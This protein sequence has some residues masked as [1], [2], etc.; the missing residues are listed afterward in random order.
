M[1]R[2][3]TPLLAGFAVVA[4]LGLGLPSIG[5]EKPAAP[6]DRSATD[7]AA[8]NFAVEHEIG[9]RFRIDPNDLPAP[10]TAQSS[11]TGC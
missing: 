5:A 9:H 7:P 8:Q 4:S 10:K 6:Q 11:P 1:A 3:L 2:N